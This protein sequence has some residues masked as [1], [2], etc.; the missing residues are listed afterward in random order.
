MS[1][2][3]IMYHLLRYL[4]IKSNFQHFVAKNFIRTILWIYFDLNRMFL[5]CLN[6]S[7]PQVIYFHMS[8]LWGKLPINS[9]FHGNQILGIYGENGRTKRSIDI[10]NGY[11]SRLNR[12]F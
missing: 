8:H 7:Y 6:W 5:F 11:I 12:M 3:G 4:V 1:K 10:P 2:L 9:S